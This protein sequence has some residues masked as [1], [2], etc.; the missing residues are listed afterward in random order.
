METDRN[1]SHRN[2]RGGGGGGD[3]G[4]RGGDN[5]G[6][7]SGNGGQKKSSQHSTHNKMRFCDVDFRE[8]VR[9]PK[10]VIRQI[11]SHFGYGENGQ[12]SAEF[13]RA[14]DAFMV[15]NPRCVRCWLVWLCFTMPW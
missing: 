6:G 15:A 10:S 14:I 2:R 8:L 7:S 1:S 11:Y 3:C 9:D 13:E 5:D 12:L 4:V